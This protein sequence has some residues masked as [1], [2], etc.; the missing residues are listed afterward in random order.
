M[1]AKS[2]FIRCAHALACAC[3]LWCGTASA[4]EILTIYGRT[5]CGEFLSGCDTHANCT[6]LNVYTNA[7][8]HL[9]SGYASGPYDVVFTG[10]AGKPA[11]QLN[12]PAGQDAIVT[13]TQA[14]NYTATGK[15]GPSASASL[16]IVVT[17]QPNQGPA[18]AV[19]TLYYTF[20]WPTDRF[21]DMSGHG[22]QGER[23]LAEP[24]LLDGV[25]SV[26]GIMFGKSI[27]F[28]S[29][30]GERTDTPEYYTDDA[31]DLHVVSDDLTGM[32]WIRPAGAH[33]SEPGCTDGT[34]FSKA[35]ANWFE[36]TQNND[37]VLLQNDGSGLPGTLAQVSFPNT[38][39]SPGGHLTIDQW[40]HVA[41][42]R[43]YD[44]INENYQVT[45]FLNGVKIGTTQT[46][47]GAIDDNSA[48]LSFGNYGFHGP[49]ECEFNG[50]LDE[51][52][53]DNRCWS[54][55]E[56]FAEYHRIHDAST[57]VP[58]GSPGA[59]LVCALLMLGV[60]V[61]VSRRAFAPKA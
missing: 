3:L 20:D 56:I 39:A 45:F 34:I 50:R 49:W 22:H 24:A 11:N 37:A 51:I 23:P 54:D 40:H 2:L 53:L 19:P 60:G 31:P 30:S 28:S 59:T 10:G 29:T 7:P 16:P 17:D 13:F 4:A 41:F 12:I 9:I 52:R 14:G 42:V 32:A 15:V 44:P 26:N 33:D 48:K 25:V 38:P 21:R 46:I 58:I 5:S 43:R 55:A 27:R 57:I 61:V 18:P 6:P 36:I 8:V 1:P 35:G 47:T